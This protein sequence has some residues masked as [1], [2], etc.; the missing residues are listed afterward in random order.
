MLN[1]FG[2]GD[3]YIDVSTSQMSSEF[4]DDYTERLFEGVSHWISMD[5][6][7]G[8]NDAMEKYLRARG[9]LK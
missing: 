6:P 5:D 2:T 7:E 3:R 4:V 8:L 1:L 9:L